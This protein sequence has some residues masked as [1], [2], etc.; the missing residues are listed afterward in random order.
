AAQPQKDMM[1]KKEA[2]KRIVRANLNPEIKRKLTSQE[3]ISKGKSQSASK[4]NSFQQVKQRSTLPKQTN[5]KVQKRMNHRP[6]SRSGEK[7]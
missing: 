2:P 4:K 7:K 5:Q 6:K 3:I 1:L